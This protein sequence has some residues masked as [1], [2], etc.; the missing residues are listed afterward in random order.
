MKI[1][2]ISKNSA[3][4]VL[5]AL[6][7]V[8][9][10][11]VFIEHIDG[12]AMTAFLNVRRE[13]PIYS[14]ET[15]EKKIA[16]SFDAAWGAEYTSEIMDI[17]EE[18]DIRTTFFLVRFWME[19]NADKVR[20]IA[21]RGHEV[22]NHSATHPHMSTLSKEQMTAELVSTQ[23]KI[24]ELAGNNAVR[25][26]RPPFG[27][28]N[29]LLINTCRE[30]EIYPVQWDVDSL[31]W[32]EKGVDHMYQRVINKTRNGS[33]VLFHNNA[34]YISQALPKILDELMGRGYEIVPVS[35][36]IY[37]EDYGIDHTG[38]QIKKIN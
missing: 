31:D 29:D 23:D 17:V 12:K 9:L 19:E 11:I 7:L 16:I 38:R 3:I 6:Y 36:L 26:F 22:A 8:L 34:K 32:Q 35:E 28:Y 27:E 30:L 37:K 25:L 13:L 4:R 18:R 15:P 20:E 14:V 2:Y 21:Q 10:S 33:I 1:I 5:L 24:E